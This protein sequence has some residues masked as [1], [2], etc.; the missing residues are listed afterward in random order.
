[1]CVVSSRIDSIEQPVKI[2]SVRSRN[3]SHVGAPALNGHFD[4]SFVIFENM[5][6]CSR[7]GNV[8]VSQNRK[9]QANNC[10]Q[11]VSLVSVE[12]AIAAGHPDPLVLTRQ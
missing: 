3:V 12:L 9:C 5:K 7:A 4:R 8:R 10:V 6:R 2:T 1:M 11:L